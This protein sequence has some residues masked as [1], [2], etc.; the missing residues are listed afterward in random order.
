MFVVRKRLACETPDV[1]FEWLSR[2]FT[3][4]TLEAAESVTVTPVLSLIYGSY[5]PSALQKEPCKSSIFLG[6]L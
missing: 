4:T 6:S 3:E 1:S 2:D 5:S